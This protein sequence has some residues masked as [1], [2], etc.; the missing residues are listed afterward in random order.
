[1]L[2]FQDSVRETRALNLS[3]AINGASDDL[4]AALG[5]IS[6]DAD[7]LLTYCEWVAQENARQI[8]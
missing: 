6:E 3:Q 7:T 1:M 4:I 8:G 2:Q 5:R